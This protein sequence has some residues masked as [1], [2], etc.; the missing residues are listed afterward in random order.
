MKKKIITLFI[1]S[2]LFCFK[3]EAQKSKVTFGIVAGTYFNQFTGK[4]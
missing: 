2:I 1:V 3:A 4:Y